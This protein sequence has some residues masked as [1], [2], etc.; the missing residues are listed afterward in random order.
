MSDMT[1]RTSVDINAPAA[2]GW[3]LFGEG[4]G[5]W[6]DWAPGIDRSTL[7]GPLAQGVV[8]VNDTASLGTVRQEL[9]RFDR[10]GRA[11]AYE[12]SENLPPFFVKMRNDWVI[13]ELDSDRSRLTGVALFVLTD[14]AEPMRSKLEG[15]MGM[16]LEVFANAFRQ[17]MED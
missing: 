17:R 4:F 3:E 5:D 15:K 10:D 16:A 2:K 13:E 1:V 7:E 9:A 8:R 12:M 14:E 11:L 6:A